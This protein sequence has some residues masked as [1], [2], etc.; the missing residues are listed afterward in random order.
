MTV[1]AIDPGP[2]TAIFW[3]SDGKYYSLT[4]D[5]AHPSL[6][7]KPLEHLY[8]WLLQK[9]DPKRDI[10]VIERFE[11]R[12]ED[13]QEREYID[14]STGEWVGTAKF[15]CQFNDTQYRMQGA[16]DAKGFWDDD[17]LKRAGLYKLLRTKH[18]R[19]ACRH[20][21]YYH[22]FGLGMTIDNFNFWMDKLK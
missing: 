3:D 10:V 5:Y 6:S 13:A 11:Y 19:D 2:H 7:A 21:L 14:Y 15:F 4:F 22:T 8:N 9:V 1:Y 12:K 17:K 16:G 18:E 20:W